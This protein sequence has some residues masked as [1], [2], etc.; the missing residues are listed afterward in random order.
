[1]PSKYRQQTKEKLED[2]I[3]R[4]TFVSTVAPSRKEVQRMPKPLYLSEASYGNPVKDLESPEQ[5]SE[6]LAKARSKRQPHQDDDLLFASQCTSCIIQGLKCSGHKPICSQCFHS[7]STST[8]SFSSK[9]ADQ[10]SMRPLPS[11]TTPEFCSYPVQGD[12]LIPASTYKELK[13]NI[14][15]RFQRAD[16]KGEPLDRSDIAEAIPLITAIRDQELEGWVVRMTDKA[17]KG[18]TKYLLDRNPAAKADY[19][20]KTWYPKLAQEAQPYPSSK[21]LGRAIQWNRVR[22]R[23]QHDPD[24]KQRFVEAIRG[25]DQDA[26]HG[27]IDDW[28]VVDQRSV[29]RPPTTDSK[30]ADEHAKKTWIGR[31]LHERSKDLPD[32]LK[33]ERDRES[34]T[35]LESK[36]RRRKPR[37]KNKETS[38]AWT[39]REN[40]EDHGVGKETGEEAE[41]ED[42]GVPRRRFSRISASRFS[43]NV[44]ERMGFDV[45]NPQAL[46]GDKSLY[47]F[48][49]GKQSAEYASALGLDKTIQD[50]IFAENQRKDL[51]FRGAVALK[52]TKMHIKDLGWSS[53]MR[54]NASTRV[55]DKPLAV[56]V[57][58]DGIRARRPI[59]V[60]KDTYWKMSEGSPQHKTRVKTSRPWIAEK[61]EKILPSVCD[62]P[63]TSFMDAIHFY[64]SYFYTHVHPCPDIFEALD[65]PSQL[66]LGM[67]VQEVISD[68]AFQLGK[69]SQLDDMEVKREKLEFAKNNAEWQQYCT[70]K[71]HGKPMVSGGILEE[72]DLDPASKERQQQQQERQRTHIT[73]IHRE[74]QADEVYWQELQFL[75][76]KRPLDISPQDLVNIY[77][78]EDENNMSHHNGSIIDN[79]R[80]DSIQRSI[81]SEQVS[82]SDSRSEAQDKSDG[83]LDGSQL[84]PEDSP[85]GSSHDSVSAVDNEAAEDEWQG[86]KFQSPP[87]FTFESDGEVDLQDDISQDSDYEEDAVHAQHARLSAPSH[88]DIESNRLDESGIRVKEGLDEAESLSGRS[89]NELEK[90][91]EQE[92]DED[93]EAV[94][95]L[96]PTQPT[97]LSPVKVRQSHTEQDHYNGASVDEDEESDDPTT[98]CRDVDSELESSSEEEGEA[99][100]QLLPTQPTQQSQVK[101]SHSNETADQADKDLDEEDEALSRASESE[102]ESSSSDEE[103]DQLLPTQMSAPQSPSPSSSPTRTRLRSRSR[104]RSTSPVVTTLGNTRF[105]ALFGRHG[106]GGLSDDDDAD[107]LESDD[108][109]HRGIISQVVDD[110][111]SNED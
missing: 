88:K 38:G 93:E 19:M 106:R 31:T 102:H 5:K 29:F 23:L 95:Q 99:V 71:M 75:Q 55:K 107:E 14:P 52:R 58:V 60:F 36:R 33:S 62:V 104:S 44:N 13:S 48:T 81:P 97:H 90:D 41:K 72:D 65:L 20:L 77:T 110:S 63:E 105:G 2:L 109:Y 70:A 111:S 56:E 96:L 30:D 84:E 8:V 91:S 6:R 101:S 9:T 76:R 46:I 49:E 85:Q 67:I 37:R 12:L 28:K 86:Y 78:D 34:R 1:M 26:P 82:Y 64:A 74:A 35:V 68:F 100:E 39:E 45:R 42:D 15:E 69:E 43:N 17:S 59:K 22:K 47:R 7:S 10:S 21:N 27:I 103:V 40:I 92:E 87:T 24:N 53:K 54:R 25:S 79:A 108:D 50:T 73:K 11:D 51:S 61:D 89:E 57:E 32:M 83:S 80:H 16:T 94:D 4:Q 18:Y 3:L 66:A 98:P